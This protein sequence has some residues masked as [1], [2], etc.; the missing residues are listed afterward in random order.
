MRF[1]GFVRHLA[2]RVAAAP[3]DDIPAS[4]NAYAMYCLWLLMSATVHRR[5]L[6]PFESRDLFDLHGGWLIAADKQVRGPDEPRLIPLP[7]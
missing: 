3:A 5:V 6:D 4:H 1:G 7:P 2:D